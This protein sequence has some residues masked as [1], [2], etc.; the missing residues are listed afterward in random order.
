[1][2]GKVP[3]EL[4]QMAGRT[5]TIPRAAGLIA[6]LAALPAL[7]CWRATA[8]PQVEPPQ[9][10]AGRVFTEWL[11]A[12]NSADLAKITSFNNS[13][14]R[15]PRPVD[16][17]LNLR[18]QTGGFTLLRIVKSE[19]LSITVLLQERNTDQI[20]QLELVVAGQDAP[21]T[22]RE[23]LMPVSRP[24]DLAIARL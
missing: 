6:L 14:R 23:S 1:V 7:V 20:G 8:E 9:T 22:I 24:P 3:R 10:A 13:Y 21:K 19:P 11:N 12:F 17:T 15:Q 5:K 18:D 16:Q 4:G 2:D